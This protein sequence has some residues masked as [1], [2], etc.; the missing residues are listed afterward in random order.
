MMIISDHISRISHLPASID[1]KS[2]LICTV[3]LF[4]LDI[5]PL[6]LLQ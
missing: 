6:S 4:F 2:D 3:Y 5:P 1:V